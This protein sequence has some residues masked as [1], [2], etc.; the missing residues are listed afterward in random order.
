[1]IFFR[2]GNLLLYTVAFKL[3]WLST[4]PAYHWRVLVIIVKLR[5]SERFWRSFGR[6]LFYRTPS[7]DLDT[8]AFTVLLVHL[9]WVNL[10]RRWGWFFHIR[11]L[12][13]VFTE[14]VWCR[15]LLWTL[16]AAL[17]ILGS[18][19]FVA[20]D[21][22][23]IVFFL[24]SHIVLISQQVVA[25]LNWMAPIVNHICY[26]VAMRGLDHNLRWDRHG[27]IRST[28]VASLRTRW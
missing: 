7:I 1:M 23:M 22:S 14:H 11:I 5:W 26:L 9:H 6:L 28:I 25:W 24:T 2:E 17:F 8:A 18:H 10:L 15:S 13:L 16:F 21:R 19:S 4:L 12:L 3:Y 20:R 27:R